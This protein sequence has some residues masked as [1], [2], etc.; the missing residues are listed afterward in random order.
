MDTVA[1]LITNTSSRA[2]RITWDFY[3]TLV[4]SDFQDT[5]I[6]ITQA[7]SYTIQEIVEDTVCLTD[8]KKI[9][10][11]FAR[12]DNINIITSRDTTICYQ[13]SALI[14]AFTNGFANTFTWSKNR[15]FS[16]PFPSTDSLITVPLDSG[17]NI[18]YVQAG[19]DITLACEKIDSLEVN[20]IPVLATASISEDS[21][22]ENSSI[23]L[24]STLQ[25]VDRFVWDLD[26][27]RIDSTNASLFET[28]N[29]PLTT[30]DL[31]TLA[32]LYYAGLMD[33]MLQKTPL[34]LPVNTFGA[35]TEILLIH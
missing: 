25:N 6:F 1:V 12:P 34:A 21:I 30:C 28:F 5:T 29:V 35:A 11:L 24:I 18:F 7:G 27:G 23:D 22:C 8:D 20:Y 14:G 32:I 15:D 19:N 33:L 26:N 31:K 9:T 3:G 17:I 10:T 13:D 4:T 2:D 16:S